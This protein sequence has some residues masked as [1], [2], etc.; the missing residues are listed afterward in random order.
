MIYLS[1]IFPTEIIQAIGWTLLNSL[2]QGI[3][4]A[5]ILAI[6]L[7][8]L[9]KKTSQI[10]YALSITAMGLMILA[11]IVTFIIEYQS[12]S[13][14]SDALI[15]SEI[16]TF[17]AIVGQL[18]TE[19]WF[20]PFL[21]YF[22]ENIPLLVLVWV[23]GIFFLGLK[24]IGE[25]TYL[26]HLKRYRVQPVSRN[27][28]DQV[29]ALANQMGIQKSI[30]VVESLKVNT[31]MVVGF[32]KPV[33]LL[34]FG[35]VSGLSPQQIECIL[36][37]EL[38]HIKRFDFVINMIQSFVEVLLFFNPAVWWISACIRA[39]REN[40]C[41]DLAIQIT[42]DKATFVKT[43]AHLEEIRLSSSNTFAMTFSKNKKG[44]LY[45][46]RRILKNETTYHAFSKGFWGSLILIVGFF[47]ASFTTGESPN[48]V[49][50]TSSVKH[51]KTIDNEDINTNT[52][53]FDDLLSSKSLDESAL[54]EDPILTNTRSKETRLEKLP[55]LGFSQVETS[56]NTSW[57]PEK[58]T[59]KTVEDTIPDND[60]SER[61]LQLLE[62]RIAQ[63]K[64]SM[65]RYE[66][67][68]KQIQENRLKN[69]EAERAQRAAEIKLMA[70][71]LKRRSNYIETE[72]VQRMKLQ[73]EEQAL[74]LQQQFRKLAL[75]EEKVL[76]FKVA[77]LE[78]K[79]SAKKPE[80]NNALKKLELQKIDLESKKGDLSEQE[81]QER[82]TD[83]Q[84]QKQELTQYMEVEMKHQKE[85]L[86]TEIQQMKMNIE[87]ERERLEL[88]KKQI[89]L[90]TK[91][92]A[93]ELAQQRAEMAREKIKLEA[94]MKHME[95][96]NIEKLK[97]E[98]AEQKRRVAEEMEMLKMELKVLESERKRRIE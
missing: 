59:L 68:M 57:I 43:L 82:K 86:E 88:H 54:E 21:D 64:E 31:P 80:L 30:K 35:L 65:E 84:L 19:K 24:M 52:S 62:K 1:E 16:D 9:R 83:L 93:N 74:E 41:D 76:K 50:N 28:Q 26:N 69:V 94:Q 10:R 58:S 78:K 60:K 72:A 2:W 77:E 11:A 55:E 38:A 8:G 95:N 75:E 39:E 15:L 96:F 87:F 33:I 66:R 42:G 20:T 36:A 13:H 37:H 45:R 97:Q 51:T 81:Y 44:V 46:I 63:V 17:S 85:L 32:F 3:A 22:N 27:F 23:I 73:Q 40:C 12:I 71:E 49:Q 34:P 90:N 53:S 61:E 67:E 89:E 56:L 70:E 91:Q 47:C 92:M 25:L 29:I 98:M 6:L 48:F 79:L 18:S 7:F 14:I 5:I 4:I